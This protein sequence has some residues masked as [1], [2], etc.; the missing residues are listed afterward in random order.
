M[1]AVRPR[2]VPVHLAMSGDEI[3]WGQVGATR[4]STQRRVSRG[5]RRCPWPWRRWRSGS[6]VLYASLL[7]MCSIAARPTSGPRGAFTS[8]RG[9]YVDLVCPASERGSAM[10]A[11]NPERTRIQL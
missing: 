7:T 1:S 6:L 11:W 4:T 9:G 8:M 10:T 2:L 3:A 5:G